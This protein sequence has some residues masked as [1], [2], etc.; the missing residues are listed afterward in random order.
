MKLVKARKTGR[1]ASGS[2]LGAG[3]IVHL[4]NKRDCS[5]DLDRWDCAVC[6]TFPGRLT[7]GWQWLPDDTELRV[8]KTCE[9]RRNH[10]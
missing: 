1:L 9:K 8:C 10:G 2:E 7:C 4:I 6:G 5:S 3:K